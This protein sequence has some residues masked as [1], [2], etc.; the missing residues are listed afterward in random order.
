[1]NGEILNFL[2]R[3]GTVVGAAEEILDLHSS[4]KEHS[5]CDDCQYVRSLG[6]RMGDVLL[7]MF[8]LGT[9]HQ[10]HEEIQSEWRVEP[11]KKSMD[12]F[13]QSDYQYCC[14]HHHQSGTELVD[15]CLWCLLHKTM[16]VEKSLLFL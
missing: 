16:T 7:A 11:L 15:N 6:T 1:M 9:R 14:Y 3:M 12:Y 13:L 5:V 10:G 4:S 2:V 8:L